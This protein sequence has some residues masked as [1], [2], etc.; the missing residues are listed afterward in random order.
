M[1]ATQD[2]RAVGKVM[3]A[4]GASS[5]NLTGTSFYLCEL[6]VSPAVNFELASVFET[7]M[8][9]GDP[10]ILII[11]LLSEYQSFSLLRLV[12]MSQLIELEGELEK[13]GT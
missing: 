9:R 4:D 7:K 11:T 3:S 10:M 2:S 8:K 1:L 6:Q 5:L 12:E 13:S